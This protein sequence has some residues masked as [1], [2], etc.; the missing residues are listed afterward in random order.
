MNLCDILS[1]LG[2][3]QLRKVDQ[4]WQERC[5]IRTKY[6]EAFRSL[7]ELQLPPADAGDV[8]AWHLYI[9]RIRPELLEVNRN[10]FIEEL[11]KVGIGTS[12]HFIPLHIHPYYA[13]TYGYHEK[14]FPNAN[15]AFSRCLSLPIYPDMSEQEVQRV[16]A[17]VQGVVQKNR[18][19]KSVA[20]MQ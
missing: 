5:Q 16:I 7:P 8:H 9:L 12:V 4:F 10:Q 11:K 2:R 3:A 15:D 18:K 19:T 17:G 14:D 13:R 20:A 1:A 6:D